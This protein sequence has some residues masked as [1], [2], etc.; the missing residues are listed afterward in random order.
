MKLNAAEGVFVTSD[1]DKSLLR[2]PFVADEWPVSNA[3]DLFKI[4]EVRAQELLLEQVSDDDTYEVEIHPVALWE[5]DSLLR[6]TNLIVPHFE[7]ADEAE[8]YL[9]MHDAYG[10]E[11]E[12]D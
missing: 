7:I 1:I 11:S 12:D 6:M 10:S 9:S 5:R 8:D 3:R 4:I 2:M